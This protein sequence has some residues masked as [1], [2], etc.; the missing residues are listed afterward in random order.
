MQKQTSMSAYWIILPWHKTSFHHTVSLRI[1]KTYYSAFVFLCT[2]QVAKT[3]CLSQ[4][5]DSL[6]EAV[7]VI[8]GNAISMCPMSSEVH[9]W[10]L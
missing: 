2:A 3:L 6:H 7:Q 5:Y 1:G 8:Q 10:N 9:A 4:C